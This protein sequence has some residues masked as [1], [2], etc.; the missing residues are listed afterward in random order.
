VPEK[1]LDKQ[2]MDVVHKVQVDDEIIEWIKEA[3]RE[4]LDTETEFH[5]DA[6]TNLTQQLDQVKRFKNKVYTDH[7]E[8]QIDRELFINMMNNYRQQEI[9]IVT[10]LDVHRRADNSYID[11]GTRLLELAQHI[12]KIYETSTPAG[13]NRLL[14]IL[15]SNCILLDGQLTVT[16]HKA[17]DLIAK[18]NTLW[19]EKR[20]GSDLSEPISDMWRG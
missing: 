16:L 18:F 12:E 19:K 1:L 7:V 2:F 11:E 3:L 10:A 4:S 13:K 15:C 5:R 20:M 8:G 9:R 17:V 6:I 14:K